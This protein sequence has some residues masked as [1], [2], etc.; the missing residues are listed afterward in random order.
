MAHNT[1]IS[2]NVA[3]D[4][5]WLDAENRRIGGIRFFFAFETPG[6][7]NTTNGVPVPESGVSAEAESEITPESEV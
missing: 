6:P 5:P 1:Q 4:S 2:I 7:V 3:L